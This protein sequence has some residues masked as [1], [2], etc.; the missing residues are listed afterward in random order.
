M[1]PHRIALLLLLGSLALSARAETSATVPPSVATLSPEQQT[2]VRELSRQEID[3]AA[4]RLTEQVSQQVGKQIEGEKQAMAI[5]K[6]AL[7][8]G[9]K[10]VDWWLSNISLWLAGLGLLIAVAS[11]GIPLFIAYKLKKYSDGIKKKLEQMLKQA[12]QHTGEIEKLL[13][14][15]RDKTSLIPNA[16]TLTSQL[17]TDLLE[18]LRAEKPPQVVRLIEQAW[19]AHHQKDWATAKPLWELLSL[20]ESQ[21]A[22]VWFNLAYAESELGQDYPQITDCYRRSHLLNPSVEACNNWGNALS[23]WART[24]TGEAQQQRFAEADQHY[25]KATR[26]GPDQASAYRNWI[27]SLHY[28]TETLTGQE[29]YKCQARIDEV[30]LKAKRNL[31]TRS[32]DDLKSWRSSMDT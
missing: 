19:E 8:V 26:L 22:N 27:N 15:A 7:E 21:D 16:E 17:S 24:L 4:P 14:S 23:A 12:G 30:L 31:D 18:K 3:A 6:D 28:W 29:L 5:A 1:I 25:D 32:F 11:I 2:A 9:R 13:H 20:I 10:S